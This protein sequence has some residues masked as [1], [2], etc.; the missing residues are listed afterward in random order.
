MYS[1]VEKK[2]PSSTLK[3]VIMKINKN[4]NKSLQILKWIK[5]NKIKEARKN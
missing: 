1:L 4:K 5:Q 2:K 3:V